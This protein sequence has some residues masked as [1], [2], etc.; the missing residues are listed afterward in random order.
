MKYTIN[1]LAN[2]KGVSQPVREALLQMADYKQ[3]YEQVC[4]QYDVLAKEL[5]A[6]KQAIAA[7]PAPAP[8]GCVVVARAVLNKLGIDDAVVDTIARQAPPA[9]PAPDDLDRNACEELNCAEEVL[10]GLS[11]DLDME[12]TDF[13][14][15]GDY[16]KA[17]FAAQAKRLTP[18]AAQQPWVDIREIDI[19]VE[20]KHW[21][22]PEAFIN[23]AKWAQV[24]LKGKNT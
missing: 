20:A 24:E 19:M 7:Q 6:I 15:I 10:D 14:C 11:V 21:R 1:E 23:G 4:E 5:E 9:Q 22:N 2:S 3:L 13:D 17:V 18:T 12:K 8:K 16:I